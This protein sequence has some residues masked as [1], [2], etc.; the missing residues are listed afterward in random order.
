MSVSNTGFCFALCALATGPFAAMGAAQ[1]IGSELW[2]LDGCSSSA[3]KLARIRQSDPMQVRYSVAG[4][5]Q[6]CYAVTVALGNMPVRGYFLG[7]AHPS[8]AGFEREARSR[9]PA[10]SI[11]EKRK[12]DTPVSSEPAKVSAPVRFS[13]LRAADVR[14]RRV[15]LD[16]M[17]APVVVLY[18][19]STRDPKAIKDIEMLGYINEQY[20]RLGVELVGI[21]SGPNAKSVS[22]ISQ[23]HE[24]TWSQI[25]DAGEIV[26]KYSVALERPYYVLDRQRNAI[27]SL[28]SAKELDA[29]LQ[30]LD[31]H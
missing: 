10:V 28:S 7:S 11:P 17:P 6:T 23:E 20:H 24:A 25:L 14:G 26:K 30:R 15:D 9:V 5:E 19:W 27:A 12:A 4:D 16:A 21:A 18:F 3:A 8:V 29:V 22:R 31:S 13:G 2:I 1:P